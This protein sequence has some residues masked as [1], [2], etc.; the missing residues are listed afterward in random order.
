M[1]DQKRAMQLNAGQ[2]ARL[3]KITRTTSR[4]PD[5]DV[6]VLFLSHSVGMRVTEISRLTIADVMQTSGKLRTEISLR[7]AI[8]K[9]CRQRLAYLSSKGLIT[10]MEAYLAHRV[11]NDIGMDLGERKYRGLLPNQPLIFSGRGSGLSQNTKRRTLESGERRDY[12]ACDS[13]QARIS[14]LY[15][16]AGIKGSSHSGRRGFA[17]KILAK[18]GDMEIVATLLGHSDISCSERY[19]DIDPAVLCEMFANVL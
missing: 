11:A 7:E 10:A 5:R 12:A 19:I 18:T 14:V 13:L 16:R 3:I 9:G 8:T 4:Y 2:F 1:Q 6:L 15:M 17:T